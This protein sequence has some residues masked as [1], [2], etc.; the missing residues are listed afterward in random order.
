MLNPGTA[1]GD[2]NA[3]CFDAFANKLAGSGVGGG[4]D[5]RLRQRHS[6]TV[7]LPGYTGSATDISA[8]TAFTIAQNSPPT[9]TALVLLDSSGFAGGGPCNTP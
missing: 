1:T 2:T 7:R 4:A 9:P 5:I 3:V 6:S 8:V